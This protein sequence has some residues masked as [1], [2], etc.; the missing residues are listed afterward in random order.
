MNIP[1]NI[2]PIRAHSRCCRFETYP[3]GIWE[4]VR[5]NHRPGE[6]D[7]E[8]AERMLLNESLSAYGGRQQQAA[9]ALG[10]EP[11]VLNYKAQNLRIRPRD[12]AE[13]REA[14]NADAC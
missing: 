4:I 12:I 13:Q 1:K 10:V 7:F 5:R 9:Y 3:E 11:R 8:T 6:N 2:P 14:I